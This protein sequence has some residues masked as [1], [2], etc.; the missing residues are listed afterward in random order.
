MLNEGTYFSS[1]RDGVIMKITTFFTLFAFVFIGS[2][3][4]LSA[5]AKARK[6]SVT[7]SA[8]TKRAQTRA[9]RTESVV[10]TA[11][12]PSPASASTPASTSQVKAPSTSAQA[13]A[14]TSAA[15]AVAA[16]GGAGTGPSRAETPDIISA[17][18]GLGAASWTLTKALAKSAYE[19]ATDPAACK[20]Y[21]AAAALAASGYVIKE[22]TEGLSDAGYHKAAAL[23]ATTAI[24][25][26]ATALWKLYKYQTQSA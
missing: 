4:D 7:P 6:R 19:K 22:P 18:G 17:L 5:A 13:P 23:Y 12:A 3:V 11:K 26:C 10:S 16:T 14:S 25:V 9:E 20:V 2:A 8:R 15:P 1:Y 24:A 21:L